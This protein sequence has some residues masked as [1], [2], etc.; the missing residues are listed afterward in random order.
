MAVPD[1]R[2]AAS[3]AFQFL[4]V[5]HLALARWYIPLRGSLY[6]RNFERSTTV[7]AE[8]HRRINDIAALLDQQG[9]LTSHDATDRLAP[10]RVTTACEGYDLKDPFR[11]AVR[12]TMNPT[13]IK[14]A[15]KP[16]LA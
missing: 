11:C 9:N 4:S 16:A 8:S 14:K 6:L 3:S 2:L 5:S 13:E 1:G 12:E 15:Y 10:F 7:R